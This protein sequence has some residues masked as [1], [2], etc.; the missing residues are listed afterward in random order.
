MDIVVFPNEQTQAKEFIINQIILL[1]NSMTSSENLF[2]KP[3]GTY[4]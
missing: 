2:S 4:V 3:L 1:R